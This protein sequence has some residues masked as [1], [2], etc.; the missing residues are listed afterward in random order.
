MSDKMLTHLEMTATRISP[1][2]QEQLYRMLCSGGNDFFFFRESCIEEIKKAGFCVEVPLSSQAFLEFHINDIKEILNNVNLLD[3]LPAKNRKKE[4]LSWLDTNEYNSLDLIQNRYILVEFM[5]ITTEITS[6]LFEIYSERFVKEVQKHHGDKNLLVEKV[7]P[8]FYKD[9]IEDENE[10]LPV[11]INQEQLSKETSHFDNWEKD[12]HE[13]PDQ[14]K[15]METAKKSATTPQSVDKEGMTAI[16]KGS[17]KN[18]Y[19]TTLN[20]CTCGDFFRR[21]LPCKHIY[22]LIAELNEEEVQ[23][24]VNKNELKNPL[25]VS[26]AIKLPVESQKILFDICWKAHFRNQIAFFERKSDFV[27]TLL[28]DYCVEEELS[29]KEIEDLPVADI[30]NMIFA[31]D[32]ANKPPRNTQKKKLMEWLYENEAEVLSLLRNDFV[33]LRLTPSAEFMKIAIHRKFSSIFPEE[34]VLNQEGNFLY[35]DKKTRFYV[36]D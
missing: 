1:E 5:P 31:L 35:S 9:E 21:G 30:R 34:E 32:M 20:D 29:I 36:E 3:K 15:R 8:F 11:S 14:K 13:S 10:H 4:F 17:G 22:R 18:P 19:V 25:L 24:G 7:T 27:N 33:M 6:N 16:F 2:A 12:V 26:N 23:V 28:V